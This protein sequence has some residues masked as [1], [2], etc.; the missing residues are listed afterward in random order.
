MTET[1]TIPF[2]DFLFDTSIPVRTIYG[3]NLSLKVKAGTRPGTK[4]KIAGQGR[5]SGKKTGDMF[6]I[7]DAKMP[8]TPLDPQV[9]KMIEAIRYQV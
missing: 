9:E 4:F 3:K 2:F 5:K 7:V 6:V 1:V 8:N